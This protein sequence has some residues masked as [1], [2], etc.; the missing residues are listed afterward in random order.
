PSNI[1]VDN[2]GTVKLLDFGIAKAVDGIRDE[3]TRTGAIKGKI[4][5]LSPEQADGDPIDSRADLFSL[6]VVMHEALTARRLFKGGSD[7]IAL[8]MIR[9]AKV[10][11]PSSLVEALDPEVEAVTM[12]LLARTPGARFQTGDEVVAQLEPLAQKLGGTM[13]AMK[14]FLQEMAAYT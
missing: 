6:G 1:M 2:S 10:D 12:K 3:H 4:G 14:R 8:R 11:P 7:L 5:Y 9:D 13:S